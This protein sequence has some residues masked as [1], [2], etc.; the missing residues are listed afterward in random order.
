MQDKINKLESDISK[1]EQKNKPK[2]SFGKITSKTFKNIGFK[3]KT[4]ANKVCYIIRCKNKRIH[5]WT[6]IFESLS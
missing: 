1:I 5:Q 4:I 6:S 2:L 3:S